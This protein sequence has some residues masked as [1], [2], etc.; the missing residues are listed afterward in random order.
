MHDPVGA[1]ADVLRWAEV[2]GPRGWD[3]ERR[4]ARCGSA[5]G[6]QRRAGLLTVSGHHAGRQ[7][8]PAPGQLLS[9]P[10]SAAPESSLVFGCEMDQF[11]AKTP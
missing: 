3:W 6:G 8:P 10:L 7:S 9:L 5:V 11:R 2:S 4:G 1:D